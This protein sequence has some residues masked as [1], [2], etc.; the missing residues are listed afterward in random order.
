M[1]LKKGSKIT[2][3]LIV[4]LLL[5]LALFTNVSAAE[6]EILRATAV[7]P[8]R[9]TPGHMSGS[10][11]ARVSG[12]VYDWLVRVK[13]GTM[14]IKPELA[15]SWQVS[16]NGKNWTIHLREG[17]K[18]H[19]GSKFT[20]EDVIYTVERALDPDVGH[21][22]KENFEAIAEIK[23]I[24]E[25]TIEF[26]L[27]EPNAKFMHVFTDYNSAILSSSYDYAELGDTKPMGTGP[28]E[29]ESI[30]PT[31]SAI[32]VKNTDYWVE[33]TPNVD[34][35]HWSFVPDKT[36]QLQMLRTGA[37]DM[38]MEITPQDVAML[39]GVKG[40]EGKH[41]QG[42][43]QIVLYMNVNE[44]PF[45]DNRVRQALKY[46]LDNEQIIKSAYGLLYDQVEGKVTVNESPLAPVYPE[47]NKIE[48]RERDIQKAKELL[49]EAGYGDGLEL[50]LYYAS[51]YR[52]G[53]EFALALQQMAR[54]AGIN[55][56]LVGVPRDIYLSK[57]WR[58]VDF[59]ITGWG[60]RAD[61]VTILRLA[62]KCDAPWNESHFCNEKL[63]KLVEEAAEETSL[64]ER[65][66]I[67]KE[68][69]EVFQK[70]GPVVTVNIGRWHGLNDSVKDYKEA[71]PFVGDWRYVTLTGDRNTYNPSEEK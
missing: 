50:T 25:Y 45:E 34:E 47:Y 68:I 53:P 26:K 58:N 31:E 38:A 49:E 66:Q 5:T 67:Y 62:Y 35:I 13:P 32:L 20:A 17:V 46:T 40:V 24:D 55:I 59:G 37:V 27:K 4:V 22:L 48:E 33:G 28:F 44:E 16:S 8:G 10:A 29:V 12:A 43:T 71:A 69:Q 6:K 21:A 3:T 15:K 18:F 7:T 61:P 23:K 51:N 19:D 63:D 2:F 36:T 14:E 42:T 39:R 9:L 30:E 57:H 52:V 64:E 41:M 1:C 54:P 70:T 11:A 65:K 60:N 56:E